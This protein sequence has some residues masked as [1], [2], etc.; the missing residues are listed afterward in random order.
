M[1]NDTRLLALVAGVAALAGPRRTRPLAGFL[2]GVMLS[3]THGAG[4]QRLEATIVRLF[5]ER[6]SA[7]ARLDALKDWQDDQAATTS[8]HMRRLDQIEAVLAD[9]VGAG[10]PGG[11]HAMQLIMERRLR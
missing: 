2:Y 1:S 9:T 4:R 11:E 5:D 7:L 10:D 6:K 3:R 8:S